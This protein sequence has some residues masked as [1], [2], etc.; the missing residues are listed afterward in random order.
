M[1]DAKIYFELLELLE[2]KDKTIAKQS[3]L[4]TELVK[5]KLEWCNWCRESGALE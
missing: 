4:I 2:E 1:M 5:E 3:E